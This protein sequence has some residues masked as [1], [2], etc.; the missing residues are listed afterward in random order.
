MEFQK[1]SG[2]LLERVRILNIIIFFM[3]E[4]LAQNKGEEGGFFEK[5]LKRKG[6]IKEKK[7]VQGPKGKTAFLPQDWRDKV[8]GRSEIVWC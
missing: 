2:S 6:F 5:D 3:V 8:S 7:E 4:G 1:I